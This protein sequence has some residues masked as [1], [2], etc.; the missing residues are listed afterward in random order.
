[1]FTNAE[2][3]VLLQGARQERRELG[4]W[5]MFSTGQPSPAVTSQTSTHAFCS[6]GFKIQDALA[7]AGKG[8]HSGLGGKKVWAAHQHR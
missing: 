3:H 8:L 7:L 1:M 5:T 4:K 2:S 6:L